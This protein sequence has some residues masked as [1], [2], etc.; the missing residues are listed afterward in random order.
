MSGHLKAKRHK[1]AEGEVSFI[2]KVTSS[3]IRLFKFDD[4]TNVLL[5]CA[6]IHHRGKHDFFH[7]DKINFSKIM[8]SF[9]SNFLCVDMKSE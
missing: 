9:F 7:L 5:E 4:F 2:S 1:S 8:C 6:F 3:K